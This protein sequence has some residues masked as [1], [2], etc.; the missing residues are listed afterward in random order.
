MYTMIMFPKFTQIPS[1]IPPS[2]PAQ[3]PHCTHKIV[4]LVTW[5]PEWKECCKFLVWMF[6]FYWKILHLLV[7]RECLCCMRVEGC[8][9]QVPFILKI[10]D[11]FFLSTL[12]QFCPLVALDWSQS[13]SIHLLTGCL[14]GWEPGGSWW[15]FSGCQGI[16]SVFWQKDCPRKQDQIIWGKN[17]NHL[18]MRS[19]N[20]LRR[21]TEPNMIALNI[22]L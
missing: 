14:C 2:P 10:V 21:T 11:D 1:F 7:L 22:M 19:R 16:F 6:W 9:I 3:K 15:C 8:V 18:T 12:C 5:K 13:L 4:V 20:V 17:I